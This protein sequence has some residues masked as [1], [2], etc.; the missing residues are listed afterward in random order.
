MS[1]ADYLIVDHFDYDIN[2]LIFEKNPD[3]RTDEY[4]VGT[5]NFHLA[6]P[7]KNISYGMCKKKN[8]FLFSYFILFLSFQNP[9]KLDRYRL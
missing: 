2:E 3:V 8:I 4:T 9:R 1:T 7:E 5:D 6:S